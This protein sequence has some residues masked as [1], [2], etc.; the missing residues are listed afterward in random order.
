MAEIG[1][2]ACVAAS[3]T[4]EPGSRCPVAAEPPRPSVRALRR[5][6]PCAPSVSPVP[7]V[8]AALVA[9]CGGAAARAWP[10]RQR[11]PNGNGGAQR[12]AAPGP[13]AQRRA[14]TRA[15]AASRRG[16]RRQDHPHRH[17][18]ARRHD[19]G[20]ALRAARDAISGSAA[21]SAGRTRATTATGPRPRSPTASRRAL[22]GRA[23]SVSRP[24]G[25]PHEGRQRAHRGGR[26]DRPG[27]RPRGPDQEPARQRGRAPGDLRAGDHDQDVLEVQA[28][29]TETCGQIESSTAQLKELNDRSSFATLSVPFN[30]PVVAVQ[31][32]AEGWEP[33]VSPTPSDTGLGPAGP[34]HGRDLVRHRLAA[35]PSCWS[36]W[37]GSTGVDRLGQ[38]RPTDRKRDRRPAACHVDGGGW[39]ET[40]PPGARAP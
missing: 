31:A 19:V 36:S 35:D 27:H 7:G 13:A 32:A 29:L 26:G 34:D 22:G 23:R 1:R 17:D 37:A 24:V 38:P 4:G 10:R 6:S 5:S 39:M 21:T 14:P 12:R 28:Q 33:A 30:V 11:G 16:R 25:Q 8:I 9:A 18:V 15:A 2:V 20:A 3:G 40:G